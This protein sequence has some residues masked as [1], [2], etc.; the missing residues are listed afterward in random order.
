MEKLTVSQQKFLDEMAKPKSRERNPHHRVA[1]AL[2]KKGLVAFAFL[3]G[4]FVT[5]AGMAYV[6]SSKGVTNEQANR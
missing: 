5:P 4:W 6:S 1:N 2:H 3:V